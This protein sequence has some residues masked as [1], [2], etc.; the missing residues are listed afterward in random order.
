MDETAMWSK[1]GKAWFEEEITYQIY[2]D[3]TFLQFSMNYHRV[4][5]Q[6]L[7]WGIRLSEINDDKFASVVYDRAE[8]S[9]DFLDACLDE[10]SGELP[11]YGS[12]DGALFFPLTN[13]DYRNYKPQLDDLRVVLNNETQYHTNSHAW[14]GKPNPVKKE[15]LSYPMKAFEKGGYYILQEDST[16]SFIRCGAYKDRPFQSDNLHLDLWHNGV[17][18]LWDSGSYKYNTDIETINYFI[19][20]ESHNTV[21]ISEE[22]QMLK[23]GR[24]IWNYWV[25]QAKG[26]LTETE[27]D[28]I[29]QGHIEAYRHLGGKTHRRKIIKDKA[30]LTWTVVD[31]FENAKGL[32]KNQFWQINPDVF[33]NLEMTA[34]DINGNSLTPKV[35]DTW[36]SGYYG[37]KKESKRITFAT[38]SEAIVTRI[39]IKS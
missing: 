22:N 26:R 31:E 12:N 1:K 30:S 3:G 36:Y 20:S 27:T 24:F 37:V 23:A 29:F 34:S 25:K 10:I 32:L 33:E 4:V 7:T 17:N 16:K 21:S 9:L 13:N 39:T 5:V 35:D 15:H 18:Y 8:K 19:G 14:Y 38:S 11:N 28:Y 6:L 2:D